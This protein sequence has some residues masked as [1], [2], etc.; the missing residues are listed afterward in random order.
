MRLF[1]IQVFS[2]G[3]AFAFLAGVVMFGTIIFL[4]VYF[5]AVMGMSPTQSG[6]AL[7]PAIFGIFSTSITSGQ[8]ISR[9]G[10]YKIYPVLGAVIM[11][12][13]L[14]TLSRLGVDTPFWQVAVYDLPVRGRPRVHHAD[15]RHR[16]AELGRAPGHGR[17]DQ[18]DHLLPADGRLGR[19]RPVRGRAVEPAGPLPGRAAA[20]RAS[21]RRRRPQVEAN[22][23]QAIQQLTE[24]V[25]SVVLRAFTNALDDVFLIGVPFVAVAI[26]V[27]LL[28]KEEPLRTGQP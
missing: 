25:K 21:S 14:L 18:L 1:R 17:G 3:N 10:R 7:L 16:R 12:V 23:V 22:N 26:V 13:A 6:L 27:A 20:R 28:L 24:P 19:G 11:T 15:D 2:V 4:P 8:L 5:Q 9:T